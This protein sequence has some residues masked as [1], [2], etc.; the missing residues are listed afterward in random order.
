[1]RL[2]RSFFATRCLPV[3]A[4]VA[5]ALALM[6]APKPKAFTKH[7]KAYYADPNLVG[8]ARPGLNFQIVSANIAADGTST[9]DYKVT[10]PN[11]VALDLAGVQTPGPVTAS[12]VLAYVPKG[13]AQ[14]MTY[15]TRLRT[16]ADGKSTTNVAAADTGGTSRLG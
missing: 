9:V 8:F 11:G 15:A 2:Q 13:Q 10:D 12:F 4:T 7:D 6:S 1:M 14:F 16:S 3:L 5:G